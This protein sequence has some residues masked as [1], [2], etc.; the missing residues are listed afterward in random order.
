MNQ[1][2]GKKGVK[3][4][5]Y[6]LIPPYPLWKLAEVYGIGAEKYDLR[7]WEEG[8]PFTKLFGAMQRHAWQFWA[9][10]DV[11]PENGQLHLASVAWMAFALIEMQRMRP[12]LDDR[13]HVAMN[14]D[15]QQLTSEVTNSEE[16]NTHKENP[17]LVR[18]MPKPK[19]WYS[20]C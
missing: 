8:I 13:S 9:G 2:E 14:T 1:N 12:D 5:R 17:G 15:P 18:Q 16:I 11:D 3:L 19:D 20:R 7:N 6:D 4:A 10:E